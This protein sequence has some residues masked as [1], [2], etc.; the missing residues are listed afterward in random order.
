MKIHQN[1]MVKNGKFIQNSN[2]VLVVRGEYVIDCF[3]KC[4]KCWRMIVV[5][6]RYDYGE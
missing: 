1:K 2:I 4:T 6:L 5:G 3:M